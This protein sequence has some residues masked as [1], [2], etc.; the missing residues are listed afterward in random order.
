MGILAT[1]F[2]GEWVAGLIITILIVV[3]IT[4]LCVLV[5]K[6]DKSD[7][8]S[9]VTPLETANNEVKQEEQEVLPDEEEVVGNVINLL[10]KRTYTV[11]KYNKVKPGKYHVAAAST[12]E[13]K[14]MIRV[15]GFF[16]EYEDEF[17]LSVAEGETICPVSKSITLAPVVEEVKQE[18]TEEV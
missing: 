5:L 1:V 15:N 8:A 7:K 13:N 12:D 18:Q 17:D 11:G 3:G 16:K 10:A 14:L 9:A 4:V 6:K 2:T